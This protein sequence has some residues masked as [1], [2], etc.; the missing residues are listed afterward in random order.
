MP[1]ALFIKLADFKGIYDFD[2]GNIEIPQKLLFTGNFC[3]YQERTRRTSRKME[4]K[5]GQI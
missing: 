3:T 1:E 2:Q 5:A 4:M